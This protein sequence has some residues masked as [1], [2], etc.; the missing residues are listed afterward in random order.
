MGHLCAGPRS[1]LSLSV[2][3]GRTDLEADPDRFDR[4]PGAHERMQDRQ[5]IRVPTTLPARCVFVEKKDEE[6]PEPFKATT[7]DISAGGIGMGVCLPGQETGPD[8]TIVR[9]TYLSVTFEL[10]G[11]MRFDQT[12]VRV[13]N[14]IEDRWERPILL[15]MFLDITEEMREQIVRHNLAQLRVLLRKGLS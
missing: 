14:V 4:V 7:M 13:I 11:L 2:E 10:P 9:G 8:R 6:I 1:A 3:G 5:F 12:E 15:C